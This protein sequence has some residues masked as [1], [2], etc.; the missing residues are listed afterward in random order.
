MYM[1]LKKLV[2]ARQNEETTYVFDK[3]LNFVDDL[4]LS[5]ELGTE[6]IR[7]EDST[8]LIKS[9][10][11]T[12]ISDVIQIKINLTKVGTFLVNFDKEEFNE[13]SRKQLFEKL[14][15][16]KDKNEPTLSTQEEKAKSILKIVDEYKP[17]YVTFANNLDL[18][19][20]ID[21]IGKKLKWNYP[22]LV[23]NLPREYSLLESVKNLFKKKDKKE[24]QAH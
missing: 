11:D 14:T 24:K 12:H 10:R 9:L 5:K 15:A 8:L 1:E 18:K 3:P 17:V 23:L 22:L 19:I 21:S 13:D 4:V 2:L 20:D 16:L 7:N 6:N